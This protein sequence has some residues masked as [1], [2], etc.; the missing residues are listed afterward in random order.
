MTKITKH[1]EKK[2]IIINCSRHICDTDFE[3]RLLAIPKCG[4]YTCACLVVTSIQSVD[5]FSSYGHRFNCPCYN[6]P[7]SLLLERSKI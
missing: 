4:M 7:R 5:N 1:P 2:H 6:G 3:L